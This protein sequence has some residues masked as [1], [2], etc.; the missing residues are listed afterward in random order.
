MQHLSH[1][2]MSGVNTWLKTHFRRMLTKQGVAVNIFS[3]KGTAGC[4]RS[5]SLDHVQYFIMFR[6]RMYKNIKNHQSAHKR[7]D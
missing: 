4:S 1:P 7:G 2:L 5:C 6:I 3:Q